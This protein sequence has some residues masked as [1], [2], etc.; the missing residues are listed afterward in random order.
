MGDFQKLDVWKEAHKLTL[1]IYKLTTKLPKSE[2]FILV[3]Q[4]RRAALSVE[5]NIAE[6]EGRFGKADKLK[7]FVDS[8]ASIKEV[9]TQLL[10]IR[11]L[12]PEL[13]TDAQEL[14]NRYEVLIKRLNKLISYRRVN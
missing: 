9:Q 4:I 1:E 7:F 6:G 10:V 12:Y 2:L 3:S 8:R 13:V 5:S 14:F 11:D